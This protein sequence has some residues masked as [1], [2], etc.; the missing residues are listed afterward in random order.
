MLFDEQIRDEDY[1]RETY[2]LPILAAVPDL[3]ARSSGG[4][5]YYS[6][7]GSSGKEAKPK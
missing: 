2:D 1:I 4:S 6:H 7:Y 3:T 5:Y